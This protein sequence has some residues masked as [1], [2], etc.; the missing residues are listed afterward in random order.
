MKHLFPLTFILCFSLSCQND[1]K[2][3]ATVTNKQKTNCVFEQPDISFAGIQLLDTA[4]TKTVLGN[5]I[6]L[7]AKPHFYLSENKLQYVKLI[8]HPGDL[9]N[10]VSIMKVGFTN[11][12]LKN[13]KNKRIDR[14]FFSGNE[15]FLG[16]P[17]VQLI[18]ILGKCFTVKNQ[19]KNSSVIVYRIEQPQDTKDGLLKK[20]NLPVY[21]ATYK[22][23]D[24]RLTEMEFGFEYP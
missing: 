20:H 1:P 19:R 21:Y 13:S 18:N 7:K 6:K 10:A 14:P 5:Q 15:I 12:A 11:E 16:M 23:W 3:N 8:V 9:V 22:L 17:K 4:S 24:D 2:A